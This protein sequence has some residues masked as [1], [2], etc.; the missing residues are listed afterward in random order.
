MKSTIDRNRA[1]RHERYALSADRLVFRGKIGDAEEHVRLVLPPDIRGQVR[2]GLHP[3]ADALHR[4][5]VPG[6]EFALDQ[7]TADRRVGPA[8]MQVVIDAQN[9]AVFQF[10]AGRSLD[11]RK[12]HVDLAAQP[13][14]FQMPAIE[15]AILDR[16]ASNRARFCAGR[17]GGQP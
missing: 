11:L 10:D 17:R 6:E 5:L 8:V 9:G 16:G 15:R 13:A 7:H 14:D 4:H 2:V 3:I 1:A 12:Q